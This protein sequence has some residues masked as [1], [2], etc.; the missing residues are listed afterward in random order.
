MSALLF[1]YTETTMIN[2]GL[3]ERK[4]VKLDRKNQPKE[5]EVTSSAPDE[6]SRPAALT[7]SASSDSPAQATRAAPDTSELGQ[8]HVLS[9][10]IQTGP[11]DQPQ[12]D[13]SDHQVSGHMLSV[14][15]G[16]GYVPQSNIQAED[17]ADLGKQGGQEEQEEP[18]NSPDGPHAE[19]AEP[20]DVLKEFEQLSPKLPD[21]PKKDMQDDLAGLFHAAF[22]TCHEMSPR[23][24]PPQSPFGSHS[25]DREE[26][27]F[28]LYG[29]AD[30]AMGGDAADGIALDASDEEQEEKSG[31]MAQPL[32]EGFMG[33]AESVAILQAGD[34]I[35][36]SCTF[37]TNL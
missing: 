12:P 29:D 37:S 7:T 35:Q 11:D 21:M 27:D 3:Q 16:T 31:E 8:G 18:F 30:E 19:H 14:R 20:H 33:D 13:E 25:Q 9:G 2:C 24:G 22:A 34:A 23:G 6:S 10:V 5:A 26:D 4:A 36:V 28:S 32:L 15:T 17:T 1:E